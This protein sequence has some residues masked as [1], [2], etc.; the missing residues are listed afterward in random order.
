MALGAYEGRNRNMGAH[1]VYMENQAESN[2]TLVEI[3]KYR[4]IGLIDRL[5]Y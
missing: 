5:W 4:G 1:I 3:P 2:L